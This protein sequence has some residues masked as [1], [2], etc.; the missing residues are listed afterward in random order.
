MY[1]AFLLAY[2]VGNAVQDFQLEQIVKRGWMNYELPMVLSPSVSWAWGLVLAAAC[3]LYVLV[4]GPLV[5]G[6]GSRV[7]APASGRLAPGPA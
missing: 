2:G 4:F 3:V 7:G 6:R 5:R 1:L